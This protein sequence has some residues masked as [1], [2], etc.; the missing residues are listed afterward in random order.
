MGRPA[1][2]APYYANFGAVG[3]QI[4]QPAIAKVD[5]VY[6]KKRMRQFVGQHSKCG[7][8][9]PHLKRFYEKFAMSYLPKYV[10]NRKTF[11]LPKIEIGRHGVLE[12]LMQSKLEREAV[13][14]RVEEVKQSSKPVFL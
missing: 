7:N 9:C 3:V 14:R 1:I 10:G 2:F 5:Y 8:N 11:A 6:F 12:H 4:E 13:A